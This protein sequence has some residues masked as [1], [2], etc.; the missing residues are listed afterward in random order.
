MTDLLPCPFCGGSAET[1]LGPIPGKWGARCKD[2]DVWRD[3]REATE[4]EAIAIWN[5]RAALKGDA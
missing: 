3:D 1:T 2:C 5:R 4:A